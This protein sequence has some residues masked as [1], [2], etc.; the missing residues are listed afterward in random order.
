MSL[1]TWVNSMMLGKAF[2]FSIFLIS[3]TTLGL[4]QVRGREHVSP[5]PGKA[6]PG[7]ILEETHSQERQGGRRKQGFPGAFGRRGGGTGSFLS[8]QVP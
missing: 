8:L 6:E 1:R 5:W 3:L 7:E 4:L 2:L